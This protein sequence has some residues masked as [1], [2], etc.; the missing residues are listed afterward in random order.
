MI[1]SEKMENTVNEEIYQFSLNSRVILFR[2][3]S[4]SVIADNNVTEHSSE[5]IF[6]IKALTQINEIIDKIFLVSKLWER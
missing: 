4:S 3:F 5:N 6:F 2:L 1:I